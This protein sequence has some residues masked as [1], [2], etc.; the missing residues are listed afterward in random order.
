M[1]K[2][3]L[4]LIF[5]A[6]TIVWGNANAQNN[7]QRY[8]VDP[9]HHIQPPHHRIIP[10]LQTPEQTIEYKQGSSHQ[11]GNYSSSST[12][13]SNS[14]QNSNRSGNTHQNSGRT[15]RNNKNNTHR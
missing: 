2:T 4:I 7:Q 13:T 12:N 15:N 5:A 14:Q 6:T 1:N 8:M 10:S 3:F 11:T 9:P